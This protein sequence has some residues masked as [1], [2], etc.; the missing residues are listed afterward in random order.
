[1][2]FFI[3]PTSTNLKGEV[4]WFHFGHLVTVHTK[5]IKHKFD[6]EGG[7]EMLLVLFFCRNRQAGDSK[8]VAKLSVDELECFSEQVLSLPCKI[9]EATLIQV[10]LG[11]SQRNRWKRGWRS[12]HTHWWLAQ[13]VNHWASM[14]PRAQ[15]MI[16]RC[17]TLESRLWLTDIGKWF[18]M[19]NLQ[20]GVIM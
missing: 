5:F 3:T 15:K 11:A 19:L 9:K 7:H 12:G 14:C 17:T 6:F 16:P 8:Y 2:R 10:S 1:M 18:S 4:Y 20:W 13:A